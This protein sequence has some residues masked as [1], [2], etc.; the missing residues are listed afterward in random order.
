MEEKTSPLEIA[1]II[2]LLLFMA[3]AGAYSLR[4]FLSSHIVTV[5][6][7]GA[8]K[9]ESAPA[10]TVEQGTV[11]RIGDRIMA[12]NGELLEVLSIGQTSA[13]L[14]AGGETKFIAAGQTV[15]IGG[16]RVTVPENGIK[17]GSEVWEREVTAILQ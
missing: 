11:L 5:E 2:V 7:P 1:V 12:P 4:V 6:L 15:T 9:T 14:I 8:G 17:Y 16:V 10:K 3:G 13:A